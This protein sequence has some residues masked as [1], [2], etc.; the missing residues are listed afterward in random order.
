MQ[1][2]LSFLGTLRMEW[3]HRE[4]RVV[5]NKS[6]LV[7]ISF[8]GGIEWRGLIKQHESS[9]RSCSQDIHARNTTK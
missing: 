9:R 3:L 1:L 8:M 7:G 2:L 4:E 5:E 6:R